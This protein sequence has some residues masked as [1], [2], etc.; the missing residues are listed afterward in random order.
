[1]GAV[2]STLEISADSSERTFASVAFL[3]SVSE[4]GAIFNSVVMSKTRIAPIGEKS[5]TLP[6][7]ELQAAVLALRLYNLIRK[8]IDVLIERVR[9]RTESRTVLQYINNE[10]RRFKSLVANR[11]AEIHA[12]SQPADWK[13]VPGVLNPA[14]D[15]TRGLSIDELNSKNSRWLHG[16]EFLWQDEAL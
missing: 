12:S 2:R 4:T 5:M 8:E 15:G 14:D 11:V 7:L 3:R 13:H 6:W 10:N 9:F 1:M 16:P